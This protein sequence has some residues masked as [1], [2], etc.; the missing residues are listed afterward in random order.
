[1][2]QA[3]DD[4]REV[5]T[6][7]HARFFGVAP[8]ERTLLPDDEAR[9]AEARFDDWFRNATAQAPVTERSRA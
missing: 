2:L 8:S 3:R 9:L 6:D 5:I 7:A 4:P 1:M